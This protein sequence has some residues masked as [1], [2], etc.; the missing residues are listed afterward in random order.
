MG[1]DLIHHRRVEGGTERSEWQLWG[2][3]LFGRRAFHDSAALEI[4]AAWEGRSAVLAHRAALCWHSCWGSPCWAVPE[5]GAVAEQCRQRR[6]PED[7]SNPRAPGSAGDAALMGCGAALPISGCRAVSC[8]CG[9]WILVP[10]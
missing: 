5:R 8:C 9:M 1:P 3:G 2:L 10:C 6:D 4:C 7:F